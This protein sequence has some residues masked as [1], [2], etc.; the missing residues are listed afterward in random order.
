MN[1]VGVVFVH[2]LTGNA[3][4]WKNTTG[5]SFIQLLE[6]DEELVKEYKFL[7][8]EYYTKV[9]SIFNSAPVQKFLSA[10]KFPKYFGYKEKIR[11]NRPIS[12]LSSLLET[13][14]RINL[15]DCDEVIFI[16]HSM[17][18]LIVKDLILNRQLN[19]GPKP[20]GY[21]S[22]AVPH[23]GSLTAQIL[24][25]LNLNA[26]ELKPLDDYV[27]NLNNEWTAQKETIPES[28]YLISL[29]DECVPDASS[30]PYKIDRSQEYVLDTDHSSICKPE[31]INSKVYLIVSKFLKAQAYKTK[32]LELSK[33]PY[34]AFDPT[35]D[36]E[37]FV[38]KMILCDIGEKG[39]D[40]AKECFFQAEIISKAANKQDIVI[41]TSLQNKVLS[42]YRQKYNKHST[43]GDSPNEIFS[44]V[45]D[46]ILEN[47]STSLKVGVDYI[48]FLHK[49][50]L[51]HQLANKL[52]KTVIW[53]ESTNL[54]D[55]KKAT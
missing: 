2:G 4:T 7:E 53:S 52:C 10:I 31:D 48:N 18:G 41:L 45:H 49:K 38:I 44:Q 39:I 13:F 46:A 21:I 14:V 36:K 27:D 30:R 43:N 17:G 47:D 51:L 3:Q 28:I 25:P 22:L 15:E 1:K 26:N 19:I 55:V 9:L 54:D 6:S 5:T 8:F 16:A 29:Y 35:F 42:I 24:A 11:S 32:M 33:T 23:K 20:I 12:K 40:D 34:T 50:G 37:I